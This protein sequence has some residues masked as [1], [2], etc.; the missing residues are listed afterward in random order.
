[1]R[2]SICETIKDDVEQW[3]LLCC[4]HKPNG[5]W[6]QRGDDEDFAAV[7][8][9]EYCVVTWKE[10]HALTAAPILKRRWKLFNGAYHIY[11]FLDDYVC[12]FFYLSSFNSLST[13]VNWIPILPVRAFIL[14]FDTNKAV[15]FFL[16]VVSAIIT[17]VHQHNWWHRYHY[18][19]VSPVFLSFKWSQEKEKERC[20]TLSHCWKRNWS[21][22]RW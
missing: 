12:S 15:L 8:G 9:W 5:K 2:R 3:K 21:Q 22:Q 14:I 4:W 11:H 20:T 6:L 17:T 1:M 10:I 7:D 13:S 18:P 16:F 19:P